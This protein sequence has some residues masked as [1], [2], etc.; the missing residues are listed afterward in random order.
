[1]KKYLFKTALC[2]LALGA[3]TSCNEDDNIPEIP[4]VPVITT[5]AYILNTGNWGANNGTIQ[6]YDMESGKVSAD[7]FQTANG[8]GIGDAQDMCVYGSKI[9]IVSSTSA[10]IEI[11]NR[12]DFKIV[13]TLP[14][15]DAANKPIEPRYLTATAGNVYFTAYDGTVSRLDTL[16]MTV[17]EKVEVGDHPEALTNANGKLYINISGYGT[18]TKVA[19]V[20]VKTFKKT[21]ELDVLLNPYDECITADNGNVYFVSC[22]DF[23]GNP[24]ATMQCINSA[25]DEVTKVCPASKIANKGDKMYFIYGDYWLS[26]ETKSISVYDLKTKETKKFVDYSAF[27][28]PSTIEVDPV[29]GDVYIIDAPASV[30]N[31]ISIYSADGVFKKKID[32]GYYTTKLSFITQ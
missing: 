18:G 6:W 23:N 32:A 22:G 19:V 12:K 2:A 7:L 11:V 8:A 1:M 28:N 29:S 13:K 17:A 15:T 4:E 21:K 27:Q 24:T 14:L 30:T 5:G 9:Y 16:S 20:D 25:T 3:F 31:T 26:A 10:K